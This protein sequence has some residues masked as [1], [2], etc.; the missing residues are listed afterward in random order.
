MD[1]AATAVL[2][3]ASE[4]AALAET[5][6]AAGGEAMVMALEDSALKRARI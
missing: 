2:E 1:K 3:A 5:S 6:E 4:A